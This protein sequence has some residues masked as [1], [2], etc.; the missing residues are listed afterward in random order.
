MSKTQ[1]AVVTGIG[2]VSP[3]GHSL[4]DFRNALFD[5]RSG[6]VPVTAFDTSHFRSGLGGEVR[7]FDPDRDLP[8]GEGAAYPDRYVQF[9]LAASHRALASAG[10]P[11]DLSG[12]RAA[13]SLG[14]CN[15]GL[16]TAE[17][18]WRAVLAGEGDRMDPRTGH[19]L[20]YSA[21]GRALAASFHVHGPTVIVTTACS[22]STN[23]LG[24]ALDLVQSG[25]V[26]IVLAGGSDAVCLTT[27]AGFSA[28]KAMAEPGPCRPF[29]GQPSEYG[30]SLG[31]G[32]A[33]WVVE[34]L[35][36]AEA[37]G[38]K[39]LAEILSYGLACDAHHLTAPDPAGDGAVRAMKAAVDRS[40]IPLDQLGS[41]N[42]HGTGTDANDRAEAKALR[43]ML[44]GTTLPITSTKSF[45]GHTLGAAG[46]LEA[47]ASVLGL[48]Q[49]FIPPTLHFAGPRPGVDM[50]VVGPAPRPGS[51]DS[52]LKVN[53]AFS[54]NNAA[55]VVARPGRARTTPV[56][57]PARRVVVTGIGA[58]T[59]IGVGAKALWEALA[60]GG[61]AVRPI[62]RFDTTGCRSHRAALLDP[63][64]W[65]QHERRIDLRPMNPIGRFATLA[66]REALERAG[67]AL[68]PRTLE[69]TGLVMGVNVGPSEEPLMRRVWSTP[70]HVAD[71]VG[72]A[73]S[74]ANSV[75]G[76]VTQ[77]LYL[78]GHG[79]TISP[80]PQ[81]GIAAMALAADAVAL[82]HAGRL[83]AG[84]ADE[85]FERAFR[86]DRSEERRVGK[87]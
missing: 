29:S 54:G 84:A 53:L 75:A 85:V 18:W 12:R 79:T 50:D 46:V 44:G 57:A 6:I 33:I 24:Q 36:S 32:A 60:G 8:A 78:K 30:M 27:W 80:G 22:S 47:T 38:A 5:G 21:L 35:E 72:F 83:V 67:L 45:L 16:R 74:V 82:G 77:A 71:P 10:L 17:A 63:F 41:I 1:R 4:E 56:P 49:D 64:D 13:L 39:P 69:T 25:R 66:A 81:T 40:G 7:D 19:L 73:E 59:P 62:A 70:D 76:Y 11:G 86:N 48:D 37:R 51:G 26:D 23:A 55:L 43:R 20:R 65:R 14:T 34:S 31:E 58:T 28:V 2:I 87:E 15:G 68:R 3:V 9:A 61:A 42:A 52:F